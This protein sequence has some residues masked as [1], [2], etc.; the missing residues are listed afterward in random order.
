M[1]D[2]FIA[3]IALALFNWLER[4]AE[5]GVVAVDADSDRDALRRAGSRLDEWMREQ[6]RLRARGKPDAGGSD[7]DDVRLPQGERRVDPVKEQDR[8]S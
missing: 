5:K 2:R 7:D 6:D 1:L 3:A 4:R 8:D